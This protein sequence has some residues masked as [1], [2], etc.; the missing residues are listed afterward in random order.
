MSINEGL[1]DVPKEVQRIFDSLSKIVDNEQSMEMSKQIRD[2]I[3]IIE[4]IYSSHTNVQK[5]TFFA[6]ASL[7]TALAERDSRLLMNKLMDIQN[8]VAMNSDIVSGG[9]NIPF[10]HLLL[11]AASLPI[12]VYNYLKWYVVYLFELLSNLYRNDT[13]AVTMQVAEIKDMLSNTSLFERAKEMYNESGRI[14]LLM[15]LSVLFGCITTYVDFQQTMIIFERLTPTAPF[16]ILPA[17]QNESIASASA[18]KALNI[19]SWTL[20]TFVVDPSLADKV[21]SDYENFVYGMFELDL[22]ISF[23][24]I[25]TLILACIILKGLDLVIK[26]KYKNYREMIGRS[27]RPPPPTLQ[28]FNSHSSNSQHY[29]SPR[30]IG[31]YSSPRTIGGYSRG[32]VAAAESFNDSPRQ[33]YN[34]PRSSVGGYYGGGTITELE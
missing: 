3:R 2:K 9:A 6:I 16:A 27:A 12:G 7:P 29:S 4:N 32:T 13:D 23:G 1:E 18:T 21:Y 31:G 25:I 26:P 14:P 33:Q 17:Y 11:S 24:L 15:I 10:K 28:S 20:N 19:A 8:R 22:K 30:T 5:D 34:S